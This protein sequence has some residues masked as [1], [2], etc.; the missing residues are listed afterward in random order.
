[1][2]YKV[3]KLQC[4]VPHGTESLTYLC[5]CN[6]WFG[7]C[8]LNVQKVKTDKPGQTVTLTKH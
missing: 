2:F 1:M 8:D 7:I 3:L 4:I 6:V 5:E